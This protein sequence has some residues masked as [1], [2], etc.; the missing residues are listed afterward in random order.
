[1]ILAGI[2]IGSN[3]ARLQI[4]RVVD[5]EDKI[6]FKK[7]QYIRFPLRLGGDVFSKGRV[8]SQK[9][10]EFMQLMKAFTIMMDLHKVD[11]YFACATSAIREAENG[12]QVVES[13]RLK[14]GL[15]IHIISGDEEAE[16]IHRVIGINLG[17]DNYLHIDVGGGSTELNLYQNKKKVA[18]R[19]FPIGSVRILKCHDRSDTWEKMLDWIGENADSRKE[20]LAI[21]TG[22]N[23][24]KIFDLANGIK[25]AT[26]GLNKLLEVRDLLKG[27]GFD[28][29]V[30]KLHLNADRADVIVPAAEI[31]IRVMQ[32]AGSDSILV[33]DVGLKDGII[34]Y[35]YEKYTAVPGI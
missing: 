23:I 1:M 29:R 20:I 18:S 11:H 33:P 8:G 19:S 15:N 32:R 30:H 12:D 25:G 21:G 17:E 27:M 35:L 2:D 6:S 4:S 22:G 26:I 16:M 31:Y 28:D 14:C 24:S 34:A 7:L 10:E 5:Y 9:V 3:A 13:I